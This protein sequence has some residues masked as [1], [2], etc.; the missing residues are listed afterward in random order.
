MKN[1]KLFWICLSSLLLLTIGLQACQ[2]DKGPQPIKYGTD[3]CAYCKMT[4]SDPRFG[5]QLQTKKGRVYNFD[6][7]QCMIAFVKE[8]KVKKEEVAAFYLPDYL[9]NKLMPAEKMYYLKSEE[10]KSP[11]RG[12]IAAFSNAA[13]LETTKA[14]VG[15]NTLTWDDLWK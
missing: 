11:M 3:Q 7:A 14:K 2:G 9:S 5:T 10:L 1:A 15:G 8:S 4:V 6:D 13:D 12:N